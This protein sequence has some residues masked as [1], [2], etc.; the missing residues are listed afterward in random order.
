MTGCGGPLPGLARHRIARLTVLD[1]G[2]FRVYAGRT[3]GIPGFLLETDL[4]ARLL[5]DT[6]FP[7]DYATDPAIAARDGL[8]AFGALIGHR[9]EHTLAGQLARLG[10]M[11]RDIDAT[12]L[13]HSHID[14]VGGLPLVAHAPVVVTRRERA[15]PRPLYFGAARPM[16]WPAAAYR[17]VEAETDLCAGL[18]LLPTPGHTPG[19]LSV[20]VTLPATGPLILA[21]DAINRESEPAEGFPDA[22]DPAT[23]RLS[24]ERLLALRDRLGAHLVY[25]H[26]PRQWDELRKAPDSYP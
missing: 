24:A 15:E 1:L 6:G 13:T 11:P 20:L 12:I 26:D 5:I 19:H 4:G 7:A 23:A 14:H 21:A 3:I 16:D 18:R 9:P 2:L 8:P 10:L 17:L 22:M 25:G